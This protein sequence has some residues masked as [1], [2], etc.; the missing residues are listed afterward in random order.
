[1]EKKPHFYQAS[2]SEPYGLAQE[3][4]QKETPPAH[5]RST[6]A[7]AKLHAYWIVVNY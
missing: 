6:Y 2:I 5:P 1:M 7:E 4:P 3:V